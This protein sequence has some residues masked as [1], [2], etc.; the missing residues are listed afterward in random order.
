MAASWD[1]S[2]WHLLAGPPEEMDGVSCVSRT[3]CMVVGVN[4][5][6][7]WNGSSWKAPPAHYRFFRTSVSCLSTKFCA[8]IGVVAIKWTGSDWVYFGSLPEIFYG[9]GVWCGGPTDC[10]AVG[11]GF[12]RTAQWDGHEWHGHAA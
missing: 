3:W 1:G 4:Q 9:L 7:F 12:P 10:M 11:A 5:A 8:S 6:E 2:A